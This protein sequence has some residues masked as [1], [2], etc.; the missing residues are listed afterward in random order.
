M[1]NPFQVPRTGPG[2]K[3]PL[4][5]WR[6]PVHGTYY[7]DIDSTGAAF[8]EFERRVLP[9]PPSAEQGSLVVVTGETG[10][11]KTSL[12]HRCVDR[13]DAE[14]NRLDAGYMSGE[15]IVD[16]SRYLYADETV[17]DRKKRIPEIC[18]QVIRSLV[19]KNVV[20]L[21]D[22]WFD[23]LRGPGHR[24]VYY[25]LAQRAVEYNF[26]LIII[27]PPVSDFVEELKEYFYLARECAKIVFFTES[28]E[29]SIKHYLEAESQAGGEIIWLRVGP[30]AES[31]GWLLVTDRLG[32][33]APGMV[34]GVREAELTRMVHEMKKIDEISIRRMG[35]VLYGA[36]EL[37]KD[38]S[39]PG[40]IKA[41]DLWEQLIPE[42]TFRT[43]A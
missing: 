8:A 28:S 34:A 21:P 1:V 35:A 7:V 32:R 38:E 5:P 19:R 39:P 26:T 13:L 12:I 15:F 43:R 20:P 36:W 4:C 14:T 33:L 42:L 11:G 17:A 41:I 9:F 24:E 30:L 31:D 3:E 6:N 27:L 40:E 29:S 22:E 37:H 18:G 25:K 23:A 16:L 10:C 2:S